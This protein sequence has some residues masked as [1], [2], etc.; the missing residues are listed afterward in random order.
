MKNSWDLI[1]FL[2]HMSASNIENTYKMLL[3]C[4]FF[5]SEHIWPCIEMSLTLFRNH[6]TSFILSYSK[7]HVLKPSCESLS[8][9]WSLCR[10]VTQSFG[11]ENPSRTM[12]AQCQVQTMHA[13]MLDSSKP[14]CEIHCIMLDQSVHSQYQL[15][16][17]CMAQSDHSGRAF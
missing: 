11:E 1:A 9:E 13:S 8:G 5:V 7:C 17:T 10:R 4:I 6:T 2:F 15:L 3:P 14:S 12:H 16:D